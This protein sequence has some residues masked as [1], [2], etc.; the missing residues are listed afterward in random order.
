MTARLDIRMDP[1]QVDAAVQGTADN[2]SGLAAEFAKL[3]PEA[4]KFASEV[5][6]SYAQLQRDNAKLRGE[7]AKVNDGTRE[8]QR[9][10]VRLKKVASEAI[11]A[12]LTPADRVRK[13]QEDL[14]AA[15]KAGLLTL[16]QYTAATNEAGQAVEDM[17]DSGASAIKSLGGQLLGLLGA[18]ASIAGVADQVKAV[19]EEAKRMRD[20]QAGTQMSAAVAQAEVVKMLGDPES[21]GQF[22]KQSETARSDSGFQDSDAW[23]TAAANVLSA[24]AG[25]Q[26]LTLSILKTIAPLQKNKPAELSALSGAVADIA[27]LQ[28]ATSE[29][30]VQKVFSMIIESIGQSRIT[31]YQAFKEAA[32]ATAAAIQTDAAAQEE[33]TGGGADATE[34]ARAIREAQAAFAAVGGAIKDPTGATT[35]TAVAALATQ[36]ESFLPE[37][38]VVVPLSDEDRAVLE[39]KIAKLREDVTAFDSRAAEAELPDATVAAPTDAERTAA[40]AKRQ[41]V[42]ALEQKL[43]GLETQGTGMRTLAERI[44]AIQESPELQAKFFETAAFERPVMPVIRSLLTNKQGEA[45]TRFE[46]AK[47]KIGTDETT[48]Q[49]TVDAVRTATPHLQLQEGSRSAES[50]IAGYDMAATAAGS[51]AQIEKLVN[52]ALDRSRS[53]EG[54]FTRWSLGKQQSVQSSRAMAMEDSD[55]ANRFNL[56]RLIMRREQIAGDGVRGRGLEQDKQR[57]INR[58]VGLEEHLSMQQLRDMAGIAGTPQDQAR[59]QGLDEEERKSVE[60]LDQVVKQLLRIAEQ[61]ERATAAGQRTADALTIAPGAGAT[62]AAAVPPVQR[63]GR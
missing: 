19:F 50:A 39:A 46:A 43:T 52:E 48:Y 36:L 25:N 49:R 9:E 13:K 18:S 45:A 6:K 56:A 3:G 7:L 59:L 58:Y 61:T 17:G 14:T 38:D 15:Y 23:N 30:D 35:K 24:T 31:S 55:Q 57:E 32:Q 28:N 37:Q 26:E 60:L 21:A 4:A 5:A 10:Q 41:Q 62:A 12:Q 51:R 1:A 40:D 16:E 29:E 8:Q 22:L 63:L 20:E 47:D 42:T 27:T 34:R 33:I 44:Q 11:E 2:V 53:Q 54:M